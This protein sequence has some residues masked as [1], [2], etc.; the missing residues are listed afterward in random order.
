MT[1][2]PFQERLERFGVPMITE[3]A[4]NPD[5]SMWDWITYDLLFFFNKS[6][7]SGAKLA[8]I[9]ERT[10]SNVSNILHGRRRINE[11]DAVK[12]DALWDT[13][14]H[15]GRLVRYAKLR[16]NTEWFG[17]FKGL[18]ALASVIK[19]YEPLA[20]PGLLQLPEYAAELFRAAGALEVDRLVQERMERQ[21]VFKR[22]TPPMLWL[23][24]TENVIDWPVG[25]ETLLRKQL[26]HLLE[27]ADGPR[28]GLRLVPRSAGAHAGFDGSFSIISGP[29][30]DVAYTEAPGGGRLVPSAPEVLEYGVR[31]DRI[32]HAALPEVVSLE[33]I[34][35]KM[36]SL[37]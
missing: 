27:V 19:A 14:G 13:N 18:E 25:G 36:E 15:F 10:P 5:T 29:S 3:P 22:T 35:Q 24:I 12:L 16:S 26:A 20:M 34:R 37:K 2:V 9:L 31:F 4:L 1:E 21:E 30:G 8:K 11:K 28:V 6:G 23:L 7:L 17:Q 32:G 33:M